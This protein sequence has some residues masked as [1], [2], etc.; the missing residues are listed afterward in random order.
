M[1]NPEYKIEDL[2]IQNFKDKEFAAA[3]LGLMNYD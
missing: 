1:T 2:E 3:L